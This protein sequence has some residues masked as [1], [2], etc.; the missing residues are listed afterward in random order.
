MPGM[1]CRAARVALV[2]LLFISVGC[3]QPTVHAVASAAPR[4][5][6]I[7][8]TNDDGVGAPGIVALREALLARG[9]RV[10]VVAPSGN[11]SGSSVALTTDGVLAVHTLEPGIYSVDGTPADCAMVGLR[12]IVKDDPVDLVVSGLNFGQN[13][14]VRVVSSGTVGAAIAAAGEGVPAIATSQTVDPNDYRK[15]PRYFP[16]AAAFTASLVDQLSTRRDGPLLPRGVVLNVNYPA[17]ERDAVSGVRLTHQGSFILYELN[18]APVGDG[19]YA[20][21]FSRAE[22]IDSDP[23]ADTRAISEGYVSVT[24]LYGSWT[25]EDRV[26]ADLHPLAEQLVPLPASS[27]P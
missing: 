7:L 15:T 12:H 11:R 16:D 20:V 22:K 3:A 14:G 6:H 17:R 19:R 10:T 26:M 24:P 4:S 8:V 25:S 13:L 9:H 5:L 18:Y 1:R 2:L 21:S 27:A 23:Y